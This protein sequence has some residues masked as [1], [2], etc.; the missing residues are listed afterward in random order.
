MLVPKLLLTPIKIRIFGPKTAKIGP[1]Y[2]F[3]VILGQI[4]AILAPLMPCRTKNTMRMRC[5]DLFR[6][7]GT[8]AYKG[9]VGALL[10]VGCGARAAL[11]V[12]HLPTLYIKLLLRVSVAGESVVDHDGYKSSWWR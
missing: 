7:V 3:L 10:V 8:K 4:L 1:K 11:L 2:A 12:E 6:Y 5:P 9:L